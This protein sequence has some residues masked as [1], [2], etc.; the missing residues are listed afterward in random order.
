MLSCR[1]ADSA[2]KTELERLPVAMAGADPAE[3][4]L[5]ANT[6]EAYVAAGCRIAYFA[7]VGGHLSDVIPEP[8]IPLNYGKPPHPR[9]G[10]RHPYSRG[11][12]YRPV[13]GVICRGIHPQPC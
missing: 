7:W 3:A 9:G 8:Q 2:A 6:V 4:G 1:P 12:G 10:Y 5:T 11:E 13:R